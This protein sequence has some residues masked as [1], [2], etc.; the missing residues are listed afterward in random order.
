MTPQGPRNAPPFIT[1]PPV[2]PAG[3]YVGG[4]VQRWMA[5]SAASGASGGVKAEH[6]CVKAGFCDLMGVCAAAHWADARPHHIA[7]PVRRFYATDAE[8]VPPGAPL[9]APAPVQRCAGGTVSECITARQP[10]RLLGTILRA[11]QHRGGVRP[12][13][14][15]RLAAAPAP[16][17]PGGIKKSVPR[18]AHKRAPAW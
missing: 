7:K 8:P 12:R 10:S 5:R 16:V 6:L 4:T 18:F 1:V 2:P 14:A 9:A 11:S 3:T 15:C 13:G 17:P